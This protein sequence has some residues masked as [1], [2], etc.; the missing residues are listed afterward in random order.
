MATLVQH[1]AWRVEF[2]EQQQ[3]VVEQGRVD[4]DAA[5]DRAA[6]WRWGR[7][8]FWLRERAAGP[9]DAAREREHDDARSLA[10]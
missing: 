5:A 10:C 8:V 7:Y 9:Y 6:R 3:K 1:Q 2:S 4:R